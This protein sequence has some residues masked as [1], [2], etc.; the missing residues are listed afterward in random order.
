MK[1]STI[2]IA[3]PLYI[4][5][6]ANTCHITS[7]PAYPYVR[8]PFSQPESPH[9]QHGII[10]F[11]AIEHHPELIKNVINCLPMCVN[12]EFVS[13]HNWLIIVL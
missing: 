13:F 4:D 7:Q 1:Y 6:F 8:P 12:L 2:C 10:Y 3:F 9:F 11:L 5:R